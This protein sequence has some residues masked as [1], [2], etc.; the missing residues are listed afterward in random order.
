[1]HASTGTTAPTGSVVFTIDGT[2]G[3]PISLGAC[4][5]VVTGNACASTSTSTLTVSGS[6]HSVSATYTPTGTF[7]TSSGS[8][9]PG[10]TVNKATPVITWANPADITYGTALSATQLNATATFNS[11]T[12]P[13]TFTYTPASG[14]V[15]PSGPNQTLHVNF[16]PTD[17]ANFNSASKDVTINVGK[18]TLTAAIIG[19]PTKPYDGNANATLTSANFSL[20]GLVGSD[21][22]TITKTT[23]TYNSKDVATATT[24]STSLIASDFTAQGSTVASNYTLP[25]TASGPGQITAKTVTAVIAGNPT[26]PY[27]GTTNATLAAANFS[28]SGLVGTESFTVTKISGSYNSKDVVSANTVSTTLAAGDFTPG[29]GTLA[30]N[31]TLPSTASG[32]G[33]ITPVTVTAAIIGDPTRPYNG[34]TNETLAPGNFS[35]TGVISGEGFSVTKST[36]TYNSKDVVNANTV[37]ASLGAGD[38]TPASGTLASNYN[39]PITASGAGHITPVTVTATI[40]GNPTRPYNGNTNAA[41]TSANFSLTGADHRREL[42]RQR[43]R[44]HLQQQRRRHRQ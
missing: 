41:L 22:F 28:L 21:S 29:T 25:T 6:P 4:T 33:N 19:N 26:R 8:L 32:A 38:F 11:S 18:V 30:S 40:I 20:T 31:Y 43:D 35:L 36:G 39:L 13:G 27:N 7:T 1:M 17:S 23:G 5:P 9:S 16:V 24:V 15:L 34:N 14:T 2:P 10:Q 42:H 12:V 3:A 44:R 37:T